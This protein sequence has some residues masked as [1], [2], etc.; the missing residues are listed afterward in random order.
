MLNEKPHYLLQKCMQFSDNKEKGWSPKFW[1]DMAFKKN[2]KKEK[3]K[4]S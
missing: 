1:R 3:E 4:K 2:R